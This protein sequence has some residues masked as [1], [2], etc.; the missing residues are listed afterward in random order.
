MERHLIEGTPYLAVSA[1]K[2]DLWRYRNGTDNISGVIN[3]GNGRAE[4]ICSYWFEFKDGDTFLIISIGGDHLPQ[5]LL[6]S[7]CQLKFGIRSYFVCDCGRRSYKLY[8]PPDR[9]ELKCM[10]CYRLRYELSGINRSSSHGKLFYI[11]NRTIKLANQR[12][13]LN[14]IV[15]KNK[16]TKKYQAFLRLCG[17]AGFHGV[18]KEAQ[19]LMA[20]ITK[21]Q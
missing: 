14:R 19:D 20:E 21:S 6:I 10:I 16:Y 13:D 18:V 2:E 5:R 15:Y 8:L 12:E 7:E 4:L 11:T 17:K 9:E 1:I 3:I